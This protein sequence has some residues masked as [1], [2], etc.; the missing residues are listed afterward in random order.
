MALPDDARNFRRGLALYRPQKW[1]A[2]MVVRLLRIAPFGSRILPHW[3]GD[4]LSSGPLS[5]ILDHLEGDLNGLLLGNPLQE[6]RRAILLTDTGSQGQ[7]IVKLGTTPLAIAKIEREGDF[8]QACDKKG[9]MMPEIHYFWKEEN[10][11]AFA[12]TFHEAPAKLSRSVLGRLFRKWAAD[13]RVCALA[14]YAE[15]KDLRSVMV[16]CQVDSMTLQE[17]EELE[18][19]QTLRHG[20]FAPW[21]LLGS[22]ADE[23]LTVI[24]W[25][26][27]EVDSI[28]GLDL[29]HYLIVP[30]LLVDGLAPFAALESA[31]ASLQNERGLQELMM[32]W[33]WRDRIDLLLKV[34]CYSMKGE[35][36]GFDDLAR[37][38]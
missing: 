19:R 29:V 12:M 11:S 3:K 7:L 34:Y 4:H 1:L 15:W 20:D 13:G 36:E 21:N 30:A 26:F 23:E 37:M 32:L 35:L 16:E 2:G 10:W 18:L 27:G 5:E 31:R 9:W 22:G 33:G 24:D 38:V 17:M 8:I 6:S 28:P 25:E 14:D